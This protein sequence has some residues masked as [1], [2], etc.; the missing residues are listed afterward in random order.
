MRLTASPGSLRARA[1]RSRPDP[2]SAQAPV[3]RERRSGGRP[4]QRISWQVT[5]IRKDAYAKANP[6]VVEQ[7]KPPHE[8]GTRLFRPEDK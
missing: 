8:R 1:G 6:I 4:G 2:Q 5:G 3:D 7:L